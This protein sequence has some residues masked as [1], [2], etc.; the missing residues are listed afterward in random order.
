VASSSPR[1]ALDLPPNQ[2]RTFLT[3]ARRL[4]F[5]RAAEELHLTQ[6]AVSAHI[7][8]LE[9]AL[10]GALFEQIGRRVGLTETG[11]IA[12]RYAER[13]LA[14][15]EDLRAEIADVQE[16]C[17]G[18]LAI[19]TSTTVGISALPDLLRQY[20]LAHPLVRL[21]IRIG[22]YPEV[23]QWLLDGHLDVG[24]MPNYAPDQRGDERLEATP[25]LEDHLVLVAEPGHRWASRPSVGPEDLMSEP[26]V[27]P[28]AGSQLRQRV[29]DLLAPFGVSPDVVAESNSLIAIARLVETGIG[30]S[31]I[32]RLAVAD[33]LAHGRLCEVPLRDVD[34]PRP[35]FL[36]IHRDKHR[37]P[38]IRAFQALLP[39]LLA[40]VEPALSH[41]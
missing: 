2:L 20:R 6:P 7:R 23:V 30:V 22:N 34:A 8:K 16:V 37:T 15:E 32:S 36:L 29:V 13:M 21:Q 18:S 31:L 24:L 5:T 4:S 40:P 12:Y 38:A 19:G 28:G 17:Q 26:F 10:G 41:A 3:V 35:V 11:Q 33:E 1:V 25:V 14:L 27:L 39:P 9:R